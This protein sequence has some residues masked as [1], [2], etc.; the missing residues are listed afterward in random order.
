MGW[1]GV[2]KGGGGA[3]SHAVEEEQYMKK[4]GTP[5]TAVVFI[6]VYSITRTF[7]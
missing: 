2:E 6:R 5:C 1:G 3:L 7:V 4:W